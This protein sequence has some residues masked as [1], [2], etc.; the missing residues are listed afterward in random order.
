MAEFVITIF[1]LFI[2][3]LLVLGFIFYHEDKRHEKRM[4]EMYKKFKDK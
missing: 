4:N 1:L 3:A 2:I